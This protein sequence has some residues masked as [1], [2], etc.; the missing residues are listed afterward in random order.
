MIAGKRNDGRYNYYLVCIW[1]FPGKTWSE[2]AADESKQEVDK[3]VGP[4]EAVIASVS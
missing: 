2:Q 4:S 3:R 1:L